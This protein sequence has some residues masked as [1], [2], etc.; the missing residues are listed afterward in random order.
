MDVNNIKTWLSQNK[1]CFVTNS[2]ALPS[3]L[4]ISSLKTYIDY[5]PIQNFWLIPGIRNNEPFYGFNAFLQMLQY[6]LSNTHFDYVIY[7]DEDCFISD[8]ESLINEFK[9]FKENEYCLAGSQDGG[10]ICHRNHSK[11]LINTFLSFWNIKL[12]RDKNISFDNILTYVNDKIFN[13]ENDMFSDFYKTLKTNKKL[14]NICNDL[15]NMNINAI[16]DFR[17]S[18]IT[19]EAPYCKIVKNDVNNVIEPYQTPYSYDDDIALVNFEPYYILEQALI[20]LTGC[21]I[22]YLFAT[23]LCDDDFINH[24]VKF[25]ISGLTSAVYTRIPSEQ[26][27]NEHTLIAVHTW[28]SRAYTK[29]PSTPLQLEQTK[30]INTIIKEFSKI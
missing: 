24:N 18:H 9:I 17:K 28:F 22:Y 13:H 15:A 16:T 14:F 10:V 30:R 26:M 3:T 6:M 21:P 19:T 23:D 29:W 12:L 2:T 8:F 25:D 11:L 4:L 20:M 1:V 5:I 27:F 7:I